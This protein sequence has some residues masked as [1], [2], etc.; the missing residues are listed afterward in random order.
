VVE[1]SISRAAIIRRLSVRDRGMVEVVVVI[2]GRRHSR[3]VF[4]PRQFKSRGHQLMLRSDN[5]SL[6]L[7]VNKPRSSVV[8]HTD[9]TKSDNSE[10]VVFSMKSRTV[11]SPLYQRQLGAQ[12][13]LVSDSQHYRCRGILRWSWGPLVLALH[14]QPDFLRQ[15]PSQVPRRRRRSANRN[16]AA[17]ELTAALLSVSSIRVFSDMRG[18]VI[19]VTIYQK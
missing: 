10:C 9:G 6:C 1:S 18:N 15:P 19:V 11:R 14:A 13:T 3:D 2:V 5:Q 7:H 17:A 8:V 12:D 4:F 16:P